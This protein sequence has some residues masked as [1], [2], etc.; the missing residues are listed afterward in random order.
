[1]CVE[2]AIEEGDI[3]TENK[4]RR[5]H[6][7]RCECRM[8]CAKYSLGFL[9][10]FLGNRC[11]VSHSLSLSLSELSRTHNNKNKHSVAALDFA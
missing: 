10:A 4:N 9:L 5:L 8:E 1:M 7:F 11:G 3:L 2:R 6:S